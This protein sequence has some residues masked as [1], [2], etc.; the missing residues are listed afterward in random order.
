M[1][2]AITGERCKK[3][4]SVTKSIIRRIFKNS[5][6]CLIRDSTLKIPGNLILKLGQESIEIDAELTNSISSVR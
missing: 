6:R 5:S 4:M 1:N 2:N 3:S